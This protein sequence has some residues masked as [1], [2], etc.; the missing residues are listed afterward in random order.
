MPLNISAW[1][2]A[3]SRVPI[4]PSTTP[5]RLIIPKQLIKFTGSTI[6]TIYDY[7]FTIKNINEQPDEDVYRTR[8]GRIPSS[9]VSVP[10]E[11]GCTTLLVYQYQYVLN[12]NLSK[13]HCSEFLL[14]FHCVGMID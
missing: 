9:R 4:P 14:R 13:P 1:P 12:Q 8:S 5:S 3:S 11:S 10:V 2:A 7:H 6:F